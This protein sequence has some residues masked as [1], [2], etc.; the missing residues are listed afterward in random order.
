[1]DTAINKYAY[2]SNFLNVYMFTSSGLQL[3]VQKNH[4]IIKLVRSKMTLTI[5]SLKVTSKKKTL[6][7]NFSVN[8]I[9]YLG[10]IWKIG[11][12]KMQK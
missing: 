4:Y 1:M 7:I 10:H 9:L 5:N 3:I 12:L 6:K 11:I 2:V 8:I